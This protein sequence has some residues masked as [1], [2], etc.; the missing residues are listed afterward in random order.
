MKQ[1][2]AGAYPASA[3]LY[4]D[5]KQEKTSRFRDVFLS[6]NCYK[7]NSP[8]FL[9]QSGRLILFYAINEINHFAHFLFQ[10]FRAVGFQIYP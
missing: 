5:T 6:I 2:P 4:K 9:Q 10:N 8:L 1:N 7:Q 3:T